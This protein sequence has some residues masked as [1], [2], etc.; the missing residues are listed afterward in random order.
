MCW[1]MSVHLRRVLTE[2]FVVLFL[3]IIKKHLLTN[4]FFLQID[5]L[6]IK[7]KRCSFFLIFTEWRLTSVIVSWHLAW[8]KSVESFSLL[9]NQQSSFRIC[10]R[11]SNGK[12]RPL[13]EVDQS[14]RS[15][16]SSKDHPAGMKYIH[17]WAPLM[18]WSLVGAGFG[19][20]LRPAHKLSVNQSIVFI[21][22]YCCYLESIF[23]GHCTEKLHV[24]RRKY[25]LGFCRWS[26]VGSYCSLSIYTSWNTSKKLRIISL[27]LT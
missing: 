14:N 4:L 2:Q 16:S 23:D 1:S 7:S 9:F 17:F 11:S 22:P 19:D 26:T 12:Q 18:K 3:I 15:F 27:K 6:R 13:C 5:L 25:F 10:F 24:I 8:N 20:M 21:I